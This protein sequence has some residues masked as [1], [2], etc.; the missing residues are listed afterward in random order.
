[1]K[2]AT[3]APPPQ[4]LLLHAPK[5]AHKTEDMDH[6]RDQKISLAECKF[7]SLLAK[8]RLKLAKSRAKFG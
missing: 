8:I 7:S 3:K 5:S 2:I 4:A 1:M 6:P